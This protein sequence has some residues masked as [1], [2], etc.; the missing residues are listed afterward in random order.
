MLP[1]DGA[2]GPGRDETPGKRQMA[3]QL[4]LHAAFWPRFISAHVGA[5]FHTGPPSAPE[6]LWAKPEWV[7]SKSLGL[8]VP[9]SK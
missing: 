3:K 5:R 8:G 9:I 1:A 4:C 2:L 6:E 7:L